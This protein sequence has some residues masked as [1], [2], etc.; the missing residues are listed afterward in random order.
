M[1]D[2]AYTFFNY[3]ITA[4]EEIGWNSFN[5]STIH[6]N[7]KNKKSSTYINNSTR[8]T[9]TT[10]EVQTVQAQ[11][12]KQKNTLY[13]NGITIPKYT[14]F[15]SITSAP[16][17]ETPTSL[18]ESTSVLGETADFAV[19][20]IRGINRD[21][22]YYDSYYNIVDRNHIFSSFLPSVKNKLSSIRTLDGEPIQNKFSDAFKH[23]LILNEE[24]EFSTTGVNAIYDTQ[25]KS[26]SPSEKTTSILSN[27][28][29]ALS[30]VTEDAVSLDPNQ[31]QIKAK[32]RLLTWWSLAEDLS[33][34]IV[35]KTSDL[36]ETT[37]YVPNTETITVK[38]SDGTVSTLSMQA[39]DYFVAKT[40]F[41]N[42]RL[43]V[44][45]D[46]ANAKT[47]T[48]ETKSRVLN[49]LNEPT[50]MEVEFSTDDSDLVEFDLDTTGVR[51]E[52]YFL[53]LDKSSITEEAASNAL[54]RKT[55][56]DYDYVTTG[57]DS[58]VQYR[59]FPTFCFFM[60]NDDVALNHLE[61]GKKATF[62][63]TDVSL[64]GLMNIFGTDIWPRN[65]PPWIIVIPT[66]IT[67]HSVFRSRSRAKD[68]S[69]RVASLIPSPNRSLARE[70][71]RNPYPLKSSIVSQGINFGVDV[72]DRVIY[73]ESVKYELDTDAITRTQRYKAGSEAVPRKEPP[74]TTMLKELNSLKSDYSLE[75][76]D[77]I[78]SY[79][80]YA[81]L[82]PSVT[83]GLMS[84][85]KDINSFKS[86]LRYNNLSTDST[87]NEN[88]LAVKD[89]SVLGSS[90]PDLLDTSISDISIINP[91]ITS[92]PS[93]GR[94]PSPE[95]RPGAPV[96]GGGY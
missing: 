12:H 57:I 94:Q 40:N 17:M 76:R 89:V 83:R 13:A 62:T 2:K 21:D 8:S 11:M 9:V 88:F 22:N 14:F 45:S 78:S 3:M 4:P 86:K 23:S 80:L 36:T 33:K 69:T 77:S 95:V 18:R 27:N 1:V 31:Y 26:I 82:N 81:R 72:E 65:I 32:N 6:Q 38:T 87:V 30:L 68:F 56:A 15:N 67:E 91:K 96:G 48:E 41:G 66:D 53:R 46:R 71:L 10:E 7:T 42:Q 84:D 54:L 75:T 24:S 74:T 19:N 16:I 79:D 34:R 61:V 92:A 5:L 47:V 93:S 59:A 50:N 51:Q 60:L 52:Y 70:G 29:K 63:F 49:L 43:T 64:G 55:K 37:I 20:G 58:Y 90:A 28:K 85:Q 39:G 35:Y 44:F 73:K 25:N